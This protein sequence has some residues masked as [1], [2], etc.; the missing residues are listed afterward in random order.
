MEVVPA[1]PVKQMRLCTRTLR[2]SRR[3]APVT[4]QAQVW[5]PPCYNPMA[6]DSYCS[7]RLIRVSD[8][9]FTSASIRTIYA[10]MLLCRGIV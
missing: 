9:C 10:H 1:S 5:T 8:F 7:V 2:V 4:G 3:A 6:D